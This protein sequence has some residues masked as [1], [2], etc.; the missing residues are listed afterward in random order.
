MSELKPNAVLRGG[1]QPV[2]PRQVRLSESADLRTWQAADG[3]GAH[4][5]SRTGQFEEF[6]G[7]LLRVYAYTG[8][9]EEP[10]KIG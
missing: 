4:V 3:S 10:P 6:A 9:A 2:G 1:P 7:G 8:P 5:W